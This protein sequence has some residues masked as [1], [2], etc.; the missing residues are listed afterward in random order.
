MPARNTPLV[1]GQYYHIFNRG[2]NRRL[3]FI[4]KREYQR[5]LSSLQYCL[6]SKR[7]VSYSKFLTL[8]QDLRQI[9]IEKLNKVPK[10]VKVIAFC[11]MPNHFHLLVKQ[12][13]DNGIS[14]LLGDFQNGYTRYFNTRNNRSGP[15]FNTQFKA[16]L[17]ETDEQLVHVSRYIHLNPYTAF[18]IKEIEELENYNWSSLP[19]Y[20]N[21]QSKITES[22]EILS[23]F[24]NAQAY[25]KFIFD[26]ADYQ[27]KLGIVKHLAIDI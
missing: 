11:L 26:Q 1:T 13:L 7:P 20:I 24:K 8:D 19:E 6:Y 22:E 5:A 27:R 2:I 15:L 23:L 4:N 21:T 25:Q 3:T 14:K 10:L 18:I 12:Q 17:I 16:V 9:I